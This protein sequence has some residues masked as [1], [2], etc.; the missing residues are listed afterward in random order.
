MGRGFF[1]GRRVDRPQDLVRVWKAAHAPERRNRKLAAAILGIGRPLVMKWYP[2]SETVFT[3]DGFLDRSGRMVALGCRKMLQWPRRLG[4]GI[5]FEGAPVAPALHEGLRALLTRAGYFGVFDA[6]FVTDGER[7]MLIDV[8]PR[9][10]NHMAFEVARGL[11]LPWLA[12]LGATGQDD[13]VS[14]TMRAVPPPATG[15]DAYVHRLPTALMLAFQGMAG[16]MSDQQRSR[17]RGWRAAHAGHITDPAHAPGDTLP[18]IVDVAFHA[19]GFLRHPRAFL[20][21][22]YRDDAAAP[23]PGARHS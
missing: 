15:T 18:A 9:F 4:P 22:L 10:Y 16:T 8:N 23:W 7:L 3:V 21:D 19:A 2:A 14:S 13:L 1:K 6:E 5:M 12:Y 20:R 17:W 11:P